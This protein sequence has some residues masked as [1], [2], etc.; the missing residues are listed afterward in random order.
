MTDWSG[1][2]DRHGRK[3]VPLSHYVY[4]YSIRVDGRMTSTTHL[5]TTT[6]GDSVFV[7]RPS[8]FQI[9]RPE[10]NTEAKFRI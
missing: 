3:P 8:P 1:I 9:M 7:I 10:A 6:I 5:N 4:T 2:T